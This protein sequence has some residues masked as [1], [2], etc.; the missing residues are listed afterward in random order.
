[1]K[2]TNSNNV[3]VSQ[4]L[5]ELSKTELLIIKIT[6]A[7]FGTVLNICCLQLIF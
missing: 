6:I 5:K 3:N 1:M 4:E 2:T 7:L